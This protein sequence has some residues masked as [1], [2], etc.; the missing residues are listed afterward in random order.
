MIQ[1]KVNIQY[2]IYGLTFSL[3]HPRG[4]KEFWDYQG[5]KSLSDSL[6]SVSTTVR[7]TGYSLLG[8][9]RT[10]PHPSCLVGLCEK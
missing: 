1:K 4:C 7:Q 10:V 2:I 5:A 3:N 6:L 9:V 8:V